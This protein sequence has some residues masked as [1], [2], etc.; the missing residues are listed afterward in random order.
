MTKIKGADSILYDQSTKILST[1]PEYFI[2]VG[3]Y[4]SHQPIQNDLDF[5]IKEP[6]N[7]V[8]VRKLLE[9]QFPDTWLL[10][11]G[12]RSKDSKRL[13]YFPII[14]HKKLVMNFW[15]SSK[16]D[17]PFFI[18]AYGYP[19]GF[20]IAIKKQVKD[21]GYHLSQ[22]GLFDNKGKKL[23]ASIIKVFEIL[24]IPFRT[25]AEEYNKHHKNNN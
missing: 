20:A 18:L 24:G 7:L 2:P 25:P 3:S 21:R 15:L 8:E 23:D 16:E 5:I 6:H 19:R 17:V 11:K 14:G 12:G 1:L 9:K 22:Y 4:L 10:T 13:D